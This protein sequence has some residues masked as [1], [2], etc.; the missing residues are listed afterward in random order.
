[1]MG[2]C[3]FWDLFWSWKSAVRQSGRTYGKWRGERGRKTG[4]FKDDL[5]LIKTDW[6]PCAM[7]V[8][9]SPCDTYCLQASNLL[10]WWECPAGEAGALNHEFVSIPGPGVEKDEGLVG[11]AATA[12]KRVSQWTSFLHELQQCLLF[13]FNLLSIKCIYI[14]LMLLFCFINHTWDVSYSSSQLGSMLG[15]ELRET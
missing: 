11:P 13:C 7:L 2:V 12:C 8:G 10:T 5:E 1:M 15:G 6:H 4:T 3:F 14:W 9:G